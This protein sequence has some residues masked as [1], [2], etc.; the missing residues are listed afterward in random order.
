MVLLVA[1]AQ[2]L[3]YL[4]R[5]LL[6]GGL[7]HHLLEAALQGSVLLYR[8]A[9]FVDCRCSDALNLAAR[10]G[11]L[12]HVCCIHR[13][14][15]R[16]GADDGVYLVDEDDYLG[17][18][19][20]FD[21]DGVDAFLELA[22]ILRSCHNGSQVKHN[23]ALAPKGSRDAVFHNALGQTFD[24]GAL[25][26]TR[27]ANQDG[28]VL[29]TARQDLGHALN[30]RFAAHHGVEQMVCCGLREVG[31]KLV[32]YGCITAL[33]A[34]GAFVVA[35]RCCCNVAILVFL[36]ILVFCKTVSSVGLGLHVEV[37]RLAQCLIRYVLFGQRL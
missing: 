4:Q 34:S 25:A 17:V 11:G 5:F 14:S 16:A 24:D 7:H 13:S 8:F 19:L 2:V 35:N 32:D 1:R 27:F 31:A 9:V 6:C 10:K 26:D 29:L 21:D 18:L 20:Q 37:E 12:E 36:V 33:V 15:C 30:L 3:Q 23:N 22:A 28:V